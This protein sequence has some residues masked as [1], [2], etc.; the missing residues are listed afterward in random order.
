M[1][2]KR[3]LA[4]AQA[5]LGLPIHQ[6]ITETPDQMRDSTANERFK[7]QEEALTQVLRAEKTRHLVLT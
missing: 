1:E 4:K 6:L 3:K 5:E 7:E 2:E